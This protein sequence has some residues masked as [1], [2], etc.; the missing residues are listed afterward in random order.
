MIAIALLLAI[1]SSGLPPADAVPDTGPQPRVERVRYSGQTVAADLVAGGVMLLVPI[2][3]HEPGFVTLGLVAFAVGAPFVH[4][5]NDNPRGAAFSFLDRLLIGGGGILLG[6][7]VM[8]DF[9][10]GGF[11]PCVNYVVGGL[12]VMGAG[13]FVASAV[14]AGFLAWRDRPVVSVGV[15]TTGRSDRGGVA[16]RIRF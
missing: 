4:L 5:A 1:E 2:I 14:D 12:A 7:V 16:L 11:D 3:T 13:L 9:C 6:L 15:M 8:N 10:T